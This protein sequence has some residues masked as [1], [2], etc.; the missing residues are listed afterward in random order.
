MSNKEMSFEKAIERLEQIVESLESG[1]CPL[2]ES[3]K[4]FEEGVKLVK[5]CNGKL[6]SVECSIKKLVNI[7]GEM[8]EEDF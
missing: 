1:T 4:I 3:L 5:L 6:E 8:V 2:E 7:N